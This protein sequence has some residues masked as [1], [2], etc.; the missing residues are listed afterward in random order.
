MDSLTPAQTSALLLEARDSLMVE[1][2][3]RMSTQP[4]EGEE[5]A[6]ASFKLHVATVRQELDHLEEHPLFPKDSDIPC[7]GVSRR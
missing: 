6:L 4:E 1:L 2:W 5:D 7:Y 3:H